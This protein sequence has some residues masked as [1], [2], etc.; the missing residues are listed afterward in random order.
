MKCKH[1]DLPNLSGTQVF[2][3]ISLCL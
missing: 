3:A 2:C 1:K